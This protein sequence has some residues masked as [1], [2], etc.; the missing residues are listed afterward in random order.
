MEFQQVVQQRR[1]VRRFTSAPVAKSSVDRL[2]RNAV[3]APSAGFTQGWA[4]LVLDQPAAVEQFWGFTTPHQGGATR[5]L[6]AWHADRAG[7]HRAAVLEG[8]VSVSLC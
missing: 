7:A 1:M 2:V 4:F 8:S 3:R 5:C 6:A